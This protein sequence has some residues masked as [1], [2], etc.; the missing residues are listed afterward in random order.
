MS[1]ANRNHPEPD[2]LRVTRHKELKLWFILGRS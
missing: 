1:C 2:W